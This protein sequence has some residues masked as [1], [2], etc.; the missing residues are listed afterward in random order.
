[1]DDMPIWVWMLVVF[2][3]VI[4][5]LLTTALGVSQLLKT[6]RFMRNAYRV[7]GTVVDVKQT[8]DFNEQT[9]TVTYHPTFSFE[10]K[11]GV[12]HSASTATAS[13]AMNYAIGS[14]R[15]ILVNP[16]MLDQVR[17]PGL[18]VWGLSVIITFFG[19]VF[20]AFGLFFLL[21]P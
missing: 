7:M 4:L 3:C 19:L 21:T 11:D 14:Q 17:M 20:G 8:T 5:P 12:T 6:R 2:M 15:Q 18:W 10:T 13:T 1:M 16:D 9:K